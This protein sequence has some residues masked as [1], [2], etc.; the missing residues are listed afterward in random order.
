MCNSDY[1]NVFAIN[2][3]NYSVREAGHKAAANSW[4]DFWTGQRKSR[5]PP[6]GSVQLVEKLYAQP[7][8]CSLY[9]ATASSSSFCASDKKLTFTV[10]DVWP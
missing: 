7:R 5:G 3:V 2:S 4:F 10:A 8:I 1:Y 6:N 9:Q